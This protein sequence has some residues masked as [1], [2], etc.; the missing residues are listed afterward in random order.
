MEQLDGK[1]A[2]V[3][4]GGSGIGEG[5]ARACADAGMRLVIA[6]IEADAAERVAGSLRE[7]GSEAIAVGTD[8]T[9]RAAL[10]ALADAAYD[11]FGEVNLLCNNAGVLTVGEI[12]A[13]TPED[14]QWLFSVNVFGVVHGIQAFVP[15]MREQI[16]ASGG[17]AHIV[18]TGSVASISTTRSVGVY[19]ATKHA[20]LGLSETLRKELEGDGIGVSILCPGGVDSRLFDAARNLPEELRG[21]VTPIVAERPDAERMQPRDVGELVVE[22]V[23]ADCFWIITHPEVRQFI[24]RRSQR[25]L[26]A[27]DEAAERAG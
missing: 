23:R 14:W 9:D 21:R 24:E 7:A 25:L 27:I 16:A 26:D 17:E 6:D 10:D 8:V 2:V 19:N 11:A 18:N 20:V 3:T 4:G 13:T 1:V 5:I 12:A 15:R 22:A